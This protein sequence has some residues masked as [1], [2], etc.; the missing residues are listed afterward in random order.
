M[1]WFTRAPTHDLS[2]EAARRGHSRDGGERG[3]VVTVRVERCLSHRS[4]SSPREPPLHVT[5]GFTITGHVYRVICSVCP[6]PAQCFS[7]KLALG[8]N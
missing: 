8:A 3:K 4:V 7:C 5:H 1:E 6:C 2:G